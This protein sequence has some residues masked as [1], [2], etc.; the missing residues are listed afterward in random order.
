V[1]LAFVL[2]HSTRMPLSAKNMIAYAPINPI[3]MLNSFLPPDDCF[4]HASRTER[5]QIDETLGA[6]SHTWTY[7]VTPNLARWINE[8][9]CPVGHGY[10]ASL[11]FYPSAFFSDYDV[12]METLGEE[13]VYDIIKSNLPEYLT[14]EEFRCNFP[15]LDCEV[16]P[17]GY[18]LENTDWTLDD[19]ELYDNWRKMEELKPPFTQFVLDLRAGTPL[20]GHP[21]KTP[22]SQAEY[23]ALPRDDK[24]NYFVPYDEMSAGCYVRVTDEQIAAMSDEQKAKV[25]WRND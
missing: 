17:G 22:I 10:R 23:D 16:L 9:D 15:Y 8:G 3:E 6:P 21:P 4:Q 1:S 19:E 12:D 5:V 13:K 25:I 18:P 24:L 2:N 20:D 7:M 11:H 14:L